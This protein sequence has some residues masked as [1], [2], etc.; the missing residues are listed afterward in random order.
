MSKVVLFAASLLLVAGIAAAGIINPCNSPVVFNGTQPECYFSCP[1]GDT[2]QF[3]Q[4]GF[5][6]QYTIN[7]VDGDPIQAVPFSDFWLVDCDEARDL[8]LCGGSGAVAG[9]D[10]STNALGNTTMSLTRFA[11][12]RCANGLSPVVQGYIL[13]T[14]TAPCPAYCFMVKVRSVDMTGDLQ[15]NIADVAMFGAAFFPNPYSECADF[16]CDTTINIQDIAL[17]GSHFGPPG[18]KCV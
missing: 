14:G 13:G 4:E 17:F 15:V 6:F 3:V 1:Q 2:R 10:S 18:H 5:H 7:D 9:A 8:V 11:V 16:N 12:G